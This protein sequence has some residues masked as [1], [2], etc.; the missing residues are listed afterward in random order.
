ME[1]GLEGYYIN[2]NMLKQIVIRLS[3]PDDKKYLSE[4]M[5]NL[6]V[7]TLQTDVA[8]ADS[9]VLRELNLY[10]QLAYDQAEG[11]LTRRL[12]KQ[13]RLHDYQDCDPS[14]SKDKAAERLLRTMVLIQEQLAAIDR[15]IAV[16]K[17]AL[18]KILKKFDRR[19]LSLLAKGE[20]ASPDE[21]VET[22]DDM[23]DPDKIRVL[24]ERLATIQLTCAEDTCVERITQCRQAM[25]KV[26]HYVL[27]RSLSF[28]G[29]VQELRLQH[30]SARFDYDY[31]QSTLR[32]F[33]ESN[34]PLQQVA[35]WFNF[36]ETVQP[37]VILLLNIL[38]PIIT[39]AIVYPVSASVIINDKNQTIF[40]TQGYFI[41]SAITIPPASHIGTLGL[42]ISC[43]CIL[44]N[45]LV[46]FRLRQRQLL[47]RGS[48][49]SGMAFTV[50]CISTLA[51]LGVASFQLHLSVVP[52]D[53]F[54]LIF[55]AM[56]VLYLA[57]ECYMDWIY[58]LETRRMR[59]F[60]LSLVATATLCVTIMFIF[61]FLGQPSPEF[62]GYNMDLLL[63]SAIAE[64][65]GFGAFLV[66][67]TTFFPSFAHTRIH[68][69]LVQK[70][71]RRAALRPVLPDKGLRHT[72]ISALMTSPTE[73]RN[74]THSVLDNFVDAAST[75]L[76]Q[77]VQSIFSTSKE[78][79][80]TA[81]RDATTKE[82][83][84]TTIQ[85]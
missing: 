77:K 44:I 17:V 41:S 19:V 6:F 55:F 37:S 70:E 59:V 54:A 53:I 64:I 73:K 8:R 80:S 63:I 60:R 79:E 52:H 28:Y 2:Y 10:E 18:H 56:G 1:N 75:S 32:A 35:R 40:D 72:S 67:F 82:A 22:I 76:D 27:A 13:L 3:D 84:L 81:V 45:A 51:G 31:Q 49:M 25:R 21:G 58:E 61:M 74:R 24:Q 29:Y 65:I 42:S 43:M 20:R 78:D 83:N 48:F 4:D 57:L 85:E 46:R 62:P 66:Y 38:I 11:S 12:E 50:C 14:V 39:V 16:N 71:V 7:S 33:E 34:A 30:W 47:G 69:V 9:F 26:E 15:F 36:K 68:A 5:I 23:P